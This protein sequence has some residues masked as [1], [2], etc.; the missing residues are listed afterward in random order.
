[1]VGIGEYDPV[2]TPQLL[3]VAEVVFAQRKRVDDDIVPVETDENAIE[4]DVAFLVK[5]GP[6][7]EIGQ[8]QGFHGNVTPVLRSGEN[9]TPPRGSFD[10]MGARLMIVNVPNSANQK[11][12]Q[13]NS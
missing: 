12:S 3:Q 2:D 10:S 6:S 11:P 7:E 5:V 9:Q 4:V 1:M 8:V 13:C